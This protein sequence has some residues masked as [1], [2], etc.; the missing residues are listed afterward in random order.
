MSYEPYQSPPPSGA[1]QDRT[2]A[3]LAHL[4]GILAYVWVGWIPALVIWLVHREKGGPA[5]AEA[6]VALNFQ[7][8]VLIGLVIC[9]VVQSIPVIGVVGWLGFIA[10]SIISLVL[11]ILAAIAVQRGGSYRYPFSLELVR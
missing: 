3:M 10:L 1:D 5:A 2:W 9:R 7:L 6:R 4:G 11:S 8:T